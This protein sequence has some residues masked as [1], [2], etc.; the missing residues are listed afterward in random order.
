MDGSAIQQ[1]ITMQVTAR[2]STG[3]IRSFTLENAALGDAF[4]M[5]CSKYSVLTVQMYAADMGDGAYTYVLVLYSD[6]DNRCIVLREEG[7]RLVTALNFLYLGETEAAYGPDGVHD[8]FVDYNNAQAA[9]CGYGVF[10]TSGSFA[11]GD[12][13]YELTILAEE[14][15]LTGGTTPIAKVYTIY[16]LS[17]GTLNIAAQERKRWN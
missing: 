13:G 15:D 1:Q 11:Q 17:G 2:E 4:V 12:A 9:N 6:I 14:A 5:D 3:A 7:G 16:R 8:G 10:R